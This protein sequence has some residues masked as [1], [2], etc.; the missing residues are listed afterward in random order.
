MNGTTTANGYQGQAFI[1]GGALSQQVGTGI[2]PPVTGV[3]DRLRQQTEI[4]HGLHQVINELENA[5]QTV[6]GPSNQIE[7]AG[8]ANKT[9]EPFTVVDKV[10]SNNNELEMAHQRLRMLVNRLQL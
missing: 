4:V 7:G 5:L 8:N 6:L 10:W 2:A 9:P 3:H 1:G